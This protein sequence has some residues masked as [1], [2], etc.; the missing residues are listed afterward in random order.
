MHLYR[1]RQVWRTARQLIV[2]GC[3]PVIIMT[4]G[5]A[6]TAAQAESSLAIDTSAWSLPAPQRSFAEHQFVAGATDKVGNGEASRLVLPIAGRPRIA[7][8]IMIRP[9][10]DTGASASDGITRDAT[11]TVAGTAQPRAKVSV[12]DGVRVLGT[13]T[14]SKLGSWTLTLPTLRDGKHKLRARVGTAMSEAVTA[15][16]DTMPPKVPTLTVGGGLYTPTPTVRGRTTAGAIVSILER[17]TILGTAEAGGD[18]RW[19]FTAPPLS[20]GTY[21][22]SSF[23]TD[24][25]GNQSGLSAAIK[26]ITD[27]SAARPVTIDLPPSSDTSRSDDNVTRNP[28]PGFAGT[29]S[30]LARVTVSDGAGIRATTRADGGGNWALTALALPVGVHRLTASAAG[31]T[32]DVLEVTVQPAPAVVDLADLFAVGAHRFDGAAA[33][34]SAGAS[35]AAAGDVDGDGRQDILIAARARSG[36][37]DRGVAHLVF[38]PTEGWPTTQDLRSLGGGGVT[39]LA[40]GPGLERPIAGLGDV[41]GDGF[42]D[43]AV[44]D[45]ARLYILFGRADLPATLE[46]ATFAEADGAVLEFDETVYSVAAAGDVNDDGIADLIVDSGGNAAVVFGSVGLASRESWDTLAGSDGFRFLG[47]QTFGHQGTRRVAGVGDVNGDGI[48]DV[49]IGANGVVRRGDDEEDITGAIHVVYGREGAFPATFNASADPASY[50]FRILGW[51]EQVIGNWITGG[52]VDGDGLGDILTSPGT[53][54]VDSAV[55]KSRLI[56]GSADGYGGTLDLR[57]PPTN[58]I[59]NLSGNLTV[60]EVADLDD[61]G[62]ADVALSSPSGTQRGTVLILYGRDVRRAGTFGPATIDGLDG[63]AIRAA[64]PGDGFGTSLAMV[65][66]ADGRGALLIGAPEADPHGRQTAGSAYL[67]TGQGGE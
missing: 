45:A 2:A 59:L 55:Y 47:V 20:P 30:P 43:V 24:V 33:E 62:L 7:P 42:A 64:D 38:G 46:L 39:I 10:S 12:L 4:L 35:V 18:G 13:T 8:T 29:A 65:S 50:G 14:A 61:D 66:G 51:F 25:A 22:F 31:R 15:V 16:V 60:S 19:S 5:G 6:G 23:A 49:A 40:P 67:V 57:V 54:F 36:V 63:F 21:R 9:R 3:A 58:Q 56:Y 1:P 27:E 52:D 37:D 34:G 26:V 44:A 17:S 53:G 28:Q 41:N 48:D 32:S 11:P